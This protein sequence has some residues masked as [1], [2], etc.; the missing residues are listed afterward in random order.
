MS[1]GFRNGE[2]ILNNDSLFVFS[3]FHFFDH[4]PRRPMPD[5]LPGTNSYQMHPAETT[6]EV[7]A[8]KKILKKIVTLL[9]ELVTVQMELN[10][11]LSNWSCTYAVNRALLFYRPGALK[12]T[13]IVLGKTKI[14]YGKFRHNFCTQCSFNSE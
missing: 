13:I 10:K 5:A 11:L 4:S 2:A 7:T 14:A 1:I 6:I 8:V 12:A 9:F 3:V